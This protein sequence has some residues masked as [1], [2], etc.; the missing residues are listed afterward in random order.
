[1]VSHLPMCKFKDIQQDLQCIH[2]KRS[3]VEMVR[4]FF[5]SMRISLS[6]YTLAYLGTIPFSF[7]FNVSKTSPHPFWLLDYGAIEHMTPLSKYF[8]K[9][10]PCLSN[11]KIVTTDHK[12]VT[13]VDTGNIKINSF[14]TLKN[15]LHVPKL[16][17]NLVFMQKTYLVS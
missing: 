3:I 6:T 1:M 5:R 2:L 13:I 14:I 7:E 10:S 4:N 16:S 9:Y 15:V 12:L 8:S 11:K 17:I